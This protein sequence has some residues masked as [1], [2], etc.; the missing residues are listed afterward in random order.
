MLPAN[1][2]LLRLIIILRSQVASSDAADLNLN[3]G[4]DCTKNVPESTMAS[5]SVPKMLFEGSEGINILLALYNSP[6]LFHDNSSSNL[7]VN[8]TVIG[9]SINNFTQL[10][11]NITLHFQL[12]RSVSYSQK[13]FSTFSNHFSAVQ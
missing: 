5:V 3:S 13:F 1:N 8:S 4:S 12:L 7:T 2:T 6:S 9:I 10:P 11:Q